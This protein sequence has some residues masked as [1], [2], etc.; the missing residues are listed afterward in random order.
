[1]SKYIYSLG[2]LLI[3]CLF[4]TLPGCGQRTAAV[5]DH[6]TRHSPLTTHEGDE[7]FPLP[8]DRGGRLLADKLRP[9]NQ[10]PRLPEDR[11]VAPKH[12]SAPAKLEAPDLPLPPVIVNAPPS[13]PLTDNRGKA[14]PI[15][16][17]LLERELPLLRQRI[18]VN[19]PATIHLPAGPKIARPSPEVNQPIPLPILARPVA[20]RASLDDFSSEAS[21]TAA[22]ASTVPDRTAPAPALR[23]NL[24]DPFEHRDAV[25]P[26]TSPPEITLPADHPRPPE[27][28]RSQEK[29]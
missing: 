4:V 3:G 15:Q 5:G 13:I 22:L 11:M 17:V 18:N 16:P 10:T 12:P 20:D 28:I 8:T 21:R 23:L 2:M 9:S 24:P 6:T 27:G 26:R 14:K 19:H 29:R 7:E 25:R 1:M